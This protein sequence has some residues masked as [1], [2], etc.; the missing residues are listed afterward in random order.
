MES[1][2]IN[3][4]RI[5]QICQCGPAEADCHPDHKENQVMK[6]INVTVIGWFV[7]R[8]IIRRRLMGQ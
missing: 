4:G 3:Y 5:Q 7:R 6:W 2:E 1:E 8:R